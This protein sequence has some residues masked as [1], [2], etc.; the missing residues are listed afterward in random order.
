[1]IRIAG[2]QVALRDR[3]ERKHQVLAATLA[4]T[5]GNA[6]GDRGEIAFV[7]PVL[8]HEAQ[9]R[10][11]APGAEFVRH[12]CKNAAG[13]RRR[14][15]RIQR[16]HHEPLDVAR[17]QPG[18]RRLDRRLAVAHC[19][20]DG[21]AVAEPASQFRGETARKR[22]GFDHQRRS[23]RGPDLPVRV[24]GASRTY[25]QDDTVQDQPPKRARHFDD[26]R[27]P[28][29]LG[30]VLADR[31]WRRILGRAEVHQQDT[32]AGRRAVRV[33]R[34]ARIRGH[35]RAV[36]A[37][38]R[39]IPRHCIRPTRAGRA[40]PR[41]LPTHARRGPGS[42]RGESHSTSI[43]SR[44]ATAQK[45]SSGS[46]VS[47]ACTAIVCTQIAPMTCCRN[48]SVLEPTPA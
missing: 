34:C 41:T 29:K 22:L 1:M 19:E 46:A 33:I 31:A 20:L 24:G 18:K 11:P 21:H 38:A 6:V 30:E 43:C 2:L 32:D 8:V 4:P 27:I 37:K 39:T 25:P 15:L 12:H 16:Q 28:E 42:M 23:L 47:V 40:E 9:F 7:L 36:D 35:A 44:L 45:M 48:P 10:H 5:G 26:T 13:R 3:V 14:K 17:A